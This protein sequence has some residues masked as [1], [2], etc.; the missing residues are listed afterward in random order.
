MSEDRVQRKDLWVR[1]GNIKQKEQWFKVAE[2]LG[3]EVTQKK[4]GSSHYP[5]RIPGT[6][7]TDISGLVV[8]VYEHGELRKDVNEKIFKAFLRAGGAEDDIWKALGLLK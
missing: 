5:I 8:T 3:F 2:K 4:G 1:L 7:V 6:A